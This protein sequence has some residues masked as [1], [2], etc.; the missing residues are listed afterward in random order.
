MSKD[1]KDINTIEV[2]NKITIGTGDNQTVIEGDTINTG[3]VTTGNTTINNDGLTIVNEDSSKNIT[4][5]N[6][7]VN[8]GGNVIKNIGEGTDPTDAINKNQFDRAI[9][10]IGTGMNQI[11]N[12]VNKLDTRISASV[13]VQLPWLLSI[14]WNSVRKRS[15][16]SRPVSVTIA[17]PMPSLSA[18]SIVRTSIPCSASVRLMAAVKT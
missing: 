3:S 4:I 5:N 1:I 2:N 16:K 9:N 18:P 10:N 17:A 14:R 8:M 6:N 13:L 11:N 12:R 15:G 7:N